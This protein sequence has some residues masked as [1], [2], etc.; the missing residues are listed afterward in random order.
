MEGR[1]A[2]KVSASSGSCDSSPVSD[3]C[4]P[5]LGRR[6]KLRR[7]LGWRGRSG[8]PVEAINAPRPKTQY[9]E[10]VESTLRDEARKFEEIRTPAKDEEIVAKEADPKR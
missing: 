7:L 10:Y 8:G 1:G 3:A 2:E 9:E 5:A 6:G 4:S